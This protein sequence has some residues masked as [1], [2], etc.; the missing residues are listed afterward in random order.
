MSSQLKGKQRAPRGNPRY[1]A[2]LPFDDY[3]HTAYP[4]ERAL[5]A[6]QSSLNVEEFTA[7]VPIDAFHLLR[8]VL[9]TL[10]GF[11]RPLLY[12]DIPDDARH[13]ACVQA[14]LL[15]QVDEYSRLPDILV[16]GED[17][18]EAAI[19]GFQPANIH[20]R[21]VHN[22]AC[23]FMKSGRAYFRLLA[24]G[25]E[26][27]KTEPLD[28]GSW[29]LALKEA[30]NAYEHKHEGPAALVP[31]KQSSAGKALELKLALEVFRTGADAAL[32]VFRHGVLVHFDDARAM[33]AREVQ[34]EELK[35]LIFI[36]IKR[37]ILLP[38]VA[39]A[40]NLVEGNPE[41]ANPGEVDPEEANSEEANPEEAYQEEV[42]PE[43]V[44]PGQQGT[45]VDAGVAAPVEEDSSSDSWEN[46]WFGEEEGLL[47]PSA[48]AEGS[49][50]DAEEPAKKTIGKKG[51]RIKNAKLLKARA[52]KNK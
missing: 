9:L 8:I 1:V 7:R 46:V 19:R 4:Y 5:G 47:E 16:G 51:K 48:P 26:R 39:E 14:Y 50:K 44:G 33:W 10:K 15:A 22:F 28:D 29:L 23:D 31:K 21:L 30:A 13:H 6:L 27:P 18:I 24:E 11:V 34:V 42:N 17:R 37:Q 32:E 43:E 45:M 49:C 3:I 40:S 25:V 35:M 20:E 52:R 38:A 36:E 12:T 41:E 2:S